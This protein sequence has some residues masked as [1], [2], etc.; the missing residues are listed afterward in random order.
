MTAVAGVELSNPGKALFPEGITKAD[1]ARYYARVAPLM[2]PHVIGRPV[3]MKRFPDGIDG[4][5]IQQKQ[6]PRH[7]P[8]WVARATVSRRRGGSVE[9][10]VIDSVRTLVYLANQACITPHV[11]LSTADAPERPDQLIFDLD[12]EVEDLAAMRAGARA[13]RRLLEAEAG[14]TAF[15]KSSGS[16][17][18]HVVAPLDGSATSDEARAFAGTVAARLAEEDP[19]RFTVEHR[20]E[21]R[22]GR[23]YVDVGRNTYAQTAAAPYA[24]RALP[25]APIAVPLSWE[26]LG[27]FA[28]R[29]YGIGNV[30]RRLGRKA[31]PWAGMADAAGSV[32]AAR[33]RFG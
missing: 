30:W 12:P 5:E 28:P 16:R 14:L 32:A 29:R 6:V 27:R 7:F 10:V 3:H 24:V 25:G 31:D 26:E 20:K 22:G 33:E 9:H 23:I 8:P 2:L 21:R 4:E 18:L 1:L 13:L 11:W 15:V 17:G 19:A